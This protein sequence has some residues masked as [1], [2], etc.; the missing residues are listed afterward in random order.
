MSSP[1]PGVSE[2]VLVVML[3]SFGLRQKEVGPRWRKG[4]VVEDKIRA[5]V[6]RFWGQAEWNPCLYPI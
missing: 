5:R 2:H 4:N 6:K 1:C 3:T